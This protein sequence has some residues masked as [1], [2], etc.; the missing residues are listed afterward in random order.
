MANLTVQV[1]ARSTRQPVKGIK[2]ALRPMR[3]GVDYDNVTD[4]DG[5]ADFMMVEP[6]SAEFFVAGALKAQIDIRPDSNVKMFGGV[7]IIVEI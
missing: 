5:M 3:L 6:G 1:V 7:P 2:V 4:S